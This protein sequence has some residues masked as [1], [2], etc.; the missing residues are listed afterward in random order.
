MQHKV[1]ILRRRFAS[2]TVLLNV[3]RVSHAAAHVLPFKIEK[4][5]NIVKEH[6]V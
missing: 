1:S 2:V 3:A 4:A 5:N 6:N